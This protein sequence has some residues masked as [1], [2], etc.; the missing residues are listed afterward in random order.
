MCS[1]NPALVFADGDNHDLGDFRRS[2]AERLESGPLKDIMTLQLRA[3]TLARPTLLPEAREQPFQTVELELLAQTAIDQLREIIA[4]LA[5][6]PSPEVPLFAQLTALCDQFRVGSGIDCQ[7]LVEPK[8]VRF[9]A[10]VNDVVYR[11]VRELLTNVRQHAYAA[12]A[13][14][15]SVERRDV[16][17]ITVSDDGIGLPP[18]ARH[19]NPTID[20]GFGLWSIEQRLQEFGGHLEIDTH[21]GTHITILLPRRLLA[22]D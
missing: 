16:V 14:I 11:A 15:A 10:A 12:N 1:A 2:L 17:A 8:H 13:K 21:S 3:A 9:D 6:E 20:G 4:E 5:D 18:E 7:L 19:R 22:L